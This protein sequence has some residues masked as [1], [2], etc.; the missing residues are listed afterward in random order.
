LLGCDEGEGGAGKQATLDASVDAGRD[1]GTTEPSDAD[2]TLSPRVEIPNPLISV[3]KPFAA[4]AS[5]SAAGS[6][7]DGAYHN[8]RRP[9]FDLS[10]AANPPWAAIELGLGPSRLLITWA[11]TGWTEYNSLSGG[12]PSAYRIETSGDTTNGA[13]GTWEVVVTVT[14]N[15][16]RTRGHGFPFEGKSWVRMVMTGAASGAT[17]VEIDEIA[18]YDT[19]A[20][21]DARPQDTWFFLGDSITKGA[22]NRNLGADGNFDEII[23]AR[24]PDYQPAIIN[25]GIGGTLSADGAARVSEMLAL[26]PDFQHI[27]ILYGT[28]DAWG[29]KDVATSGFEENLRNI[30]EP[31]LA[32][33]RVPHLARIPYAE[34]GEHD[35]LPDFNAV[36]DRLTEEYGLPAGPDL[37]AWFQAN[38]DFADGVHPSDNGYKEL[39]RL[40]A[41]SVLGLYGAVQ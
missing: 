35:T 14:D 19:S 28:N 26:Y 37:Y 31:V 9:T 41:E 8:G 21:G 16:V 5:V 6:L 27:A 24:L 17:E 36:I 11:D 23:T 13:D 38:P 2:Q 33:G 29:N 15:T 3:D 25:G 20:S 10:D 22:F 1:A 32:D 18:V 34:S 30:I 39:N 40:W 4:S 12:A 7:V